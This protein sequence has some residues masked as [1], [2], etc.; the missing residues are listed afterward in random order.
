MTTAGQLFV[1]VFRVRHSVH[2][3]LINFDTKYIQIDKEVS[4]WIAAGEVGR[5][6]PLRASHLVL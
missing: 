3:A 1:A 2:M 6:V 4:K 5:I